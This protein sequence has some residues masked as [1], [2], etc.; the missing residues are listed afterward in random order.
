M[1]LLHGQRGC[2]ILEDDLDADIQHV[3][4]ARQGAHGEAD[5]DHASERESTFLEREPEAWLEELEER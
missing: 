1:T 2:R 4:G 3:E 5:T